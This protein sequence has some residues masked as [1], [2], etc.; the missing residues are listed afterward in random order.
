MEEGAVLVIVI[1]VAAALLLVVA[2]L[3]LRSW[4]TVPRATEDD[5]FRRAAALTSD[6]S[7]THRPGVPEPDAERLGSRRPGRG[8]PPG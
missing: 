2:A 3:A 5:R 4:L 7:R 8:G 6:W 1:A